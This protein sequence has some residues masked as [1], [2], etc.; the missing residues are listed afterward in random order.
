MPAVVCQ[1]GVPS[2]RFSLFESTGAASGAHTQMVWEVDD[3]DTVVQEL[4]RPRGVR[5]NCGGPRSVRSRWD[6]EPSDSLART[7]LGMEVI[8]NTGDWALADKQR[9][10]PL[11]QLTCGCVGFPR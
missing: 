6:M 5:G 3:V 4:R 11:A 2:T 10:A 9:N 1:R 8:R 7:G